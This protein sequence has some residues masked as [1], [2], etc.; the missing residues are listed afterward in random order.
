MKPS[1]DVDVDV[2]VE[3]L[4]LLALLALDGCALAGGLD[5]ARVIVQ[6]A[7]MEAYPSVT[8]KMEAYLSVTGK[9]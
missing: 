5:E 2:D 7:M 4:A 3:A 9:L 1:S 8:D 6:A